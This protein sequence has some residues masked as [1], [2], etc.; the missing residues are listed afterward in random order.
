[1]ALSKRALYAVVAVLVVAIVLVSISVA[2]VY[3][4]PEY[5][6]DSSIRDHD[7]D[8]APDRSDPLP[9]DPT[10]WTYG[11]IRV[12]LTIHNNYS[13]AVRFIVNLC[14]IHN[15]T[16]DPV[17]NYTW[18]T[19]IRG[20]DM[21][22]RTIDVRWLMGQNRTEWMF[23]V[24]GTPDGSYYGTVLMKTTS[25]MHDGQNLTLSVTYPDDFPPLPA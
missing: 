18:I 21:A 9:S 3:E 13:I 2:Y 24:V 17:S 19:W 25:I 5:S 12:N 20:N 15:D 7:G 10:I 11:T 4:S 23:Y 8:G 14:M 6:W 16:N 22:Q 1:M